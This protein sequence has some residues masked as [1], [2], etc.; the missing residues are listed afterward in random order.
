VSDQSLLL[1]RGD[2]VAVLLRSVKP[3]EALSEAYVRR[4]HDVEYAPVPDR[5]VVFVSLNRSSFVV[6]A[7]STDGGTPEFGAGLLVPWGTEARFSPDGDMLLL[8][9]TEDLRLPPDS[10]FR[11]NRGALCV[12]FDAGPWSRSIETALE[13]T[14]DLWYGVP[15]SRYAPEGEFEVLD[16][17]FEPEG[18]RLEV[19]RHASPPAVISLAAVRRR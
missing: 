16:C 19:L 7:R 12:S 2:E 5:A 1:V 14:C 13:L 11:L 8:L 18:C 10:G 6:P 4:V 15:S 9:S 17:R 3:D